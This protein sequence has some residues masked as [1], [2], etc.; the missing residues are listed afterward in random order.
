MRV[1]QVMGAVIKAHKGE[2]DNAI[3]KAEAEKILGGGSGGGAI[4]K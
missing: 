3:A 1:Y 2:V 4:K